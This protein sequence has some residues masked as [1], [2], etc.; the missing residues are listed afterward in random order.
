MVLDTSVVLAL[1]NRKDDEHHC[2]KEIILR[3][4]PPY[5]IPAGVLAEIAYLLETRLGLHALTAFIHD[6]QSGVF[7]L[8]HDPADVTRALE[9]ATRYQNLR[10]GLS[11]GLVIACAE[12]LGGKVMSLDRHFW[13]VAGEG[14]LQVL[15]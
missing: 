15:P 5:V 7:Q 6:V 9:L 8:Q 11:D 10:L 1:L 2:V 4:I 12:R 3:E 14:T 13:I